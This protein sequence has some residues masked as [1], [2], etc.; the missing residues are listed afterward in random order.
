MLTRR[1]LIAA[2]IAALALPRGGAL[3]SNTRL[4]AHAV[5]G[6]LPG[7]LTWP[8]ARPEELAFMREVYAAHLARSGSRGAFS[9]DIPRDELGEIEEGVLLR[10]GAAR[11]ARALLAAARTALK[12]A[13]AE[14]PKPDP[15]AL[16]T[17]AVGPLSGYR[18][19]SRQFALWNKA[20]PSYFEETAPIRTALPGG[21][22]GPQAV[23]ETVEF[24]R[25][26]L[27]APGYSLHNSGKAL[28]LTTTVDG[29]MLISDRTQRAAWRASW[30]YG[31][32]TQSAPSF[33]FTENPKI[34]EPWHWEWRGG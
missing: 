3:A 15:A 11:D 27:A 17:K 23:E 31:W 33:G 25:H 4:P 22:L 29:V 5:P 28:D 30:F 21:P 1:S 2:S 12:I 9:A 8:G 7:D 10:A 24:V 20:F 6:L 16:G 14:K 19:A 13:K 18:P 32:L 34:D 26:H